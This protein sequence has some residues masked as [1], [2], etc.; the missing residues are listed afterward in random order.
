MRKS[1]IALIVA[2]SFAASVGSVLAAASDY[3]FELAGAPQKSAPDTSIASV[4]LIHVPDNKPVS[5]AVLIGEKADMSPIGMGMM[6]APVKA[7]REQKGVYQFAIRN[8]GV[9]KKPDNWLLSIDAKVQGEP[10]TVHGAVVVK[11]SP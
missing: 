9:W 5:G 11:L 7:M 8:G 1:Y 3:R 6:T 4:K 10:Q 2:G